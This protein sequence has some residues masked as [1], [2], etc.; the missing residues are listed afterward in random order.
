M[1]DVF[2]TVDVEVWCNGWENIDDKFPS[3][4]QRYVYGRTSDGEYG[5]S[6]KLKV[7]KEYGLLGVFFVEPLF[8]TRFGLQPLE[9]IV[10]LIKKHGQEVQLHLH[11]EWV[12]EAME[13][14]V[15]NDRKR[16][17]MKQFSLDE[18]SVLIA[19]GI[20]LIEQ[21]GGG[22]VNAFRAGNFGFNRDTLSALAANGIAYDS[23]YNA[24]IF[25][26]ESGVMRGQ[27]LVEP[28]RCE[29][30]YEYPMTVFDDGTGN[31][32]HVQLTACSYREIEGLLWQALEDGRKAFVILS[33]NF[34]LLNPALDRTDKLVVNRFHKLCSFLD[35]N[36][37]CF[38]VSGFTGLKPTVATI[39]PSPLTSPVW[40]TGMRMMEQIVRRRYQ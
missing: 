29:G 21:A 9:E 30:V 35:R 6:Y 24:S 4:F 19:A 38:R 37:D 31:L 12:D 10:G 36:R 32:R 34:E 33:H 25:G 22:V 28:V 18:Q 13:P 27:T 7:L 23:S 15:P 3:A 40:K 1:L 2:F 26:P 5:L 20:R 16:P 11:P 17:L 39:Q 8:A 14:L